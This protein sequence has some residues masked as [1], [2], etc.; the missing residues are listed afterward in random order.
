MPVTQDESSRAMVMAGIQQANIPALIATLRTLSNDP[1]WYSDSYRPTRGRGIEEHNDG[2]LPAERQAEIRDA[3]REAI[4][5][6]IDTGVEP[7][8]VPTRSQ[9]L[10]IAEYALGEPV[11]EPFGAW[12]FRASP[13]CSPCTDLICSRPPAAGSVIFMVERQVSYFLDLL[14]RT[15]LRPGESVEVT[16]TAFNRYQKEIDEAHS[17]LMWSVDESSSYYRN[18]T[19][20][21]VVVNPFS[22]GAFSEMTRQ[23]QLEDWRVSRC[24]RPTT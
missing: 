7:P 15:G 12:R 10:E 2:G 6:W 9:A 24:A 8:L 17:A 18:S 14:D 23:A 21:V 3:A 22:P 16:Q 13:T 11:A 19:G 1:R 4:S 5:E 20:R